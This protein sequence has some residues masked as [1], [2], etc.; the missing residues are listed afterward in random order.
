MIAFFLVAWGKRKRGAPDRGMIA[1]RPPNSRY[2]QCDVIRRKNQGPH[3]KTRGGRTRHLQPGLLP[4]WRRARER[5]SCSSMP[6]TDVS[7]GCRTL[8]L[9]LSIVGFAAEMPAL[10]ADVHRLPALSRCVA[11]NSSAR[12][13]WRRQRTSWGPRSPTGKRFAPIKWRWCMTIA[14][15]TRWRSGAPRW[16]PAAYGIGSRGWA[17]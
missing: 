10:Q 11:N 13:C 6:E 1:A 9:R 7:R 17:G 12:P 14:G 2:F 8:H 16:P 3:E 5:F 4:L 15:T